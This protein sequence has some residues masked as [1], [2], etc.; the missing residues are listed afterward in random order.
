MLGLFGT[1]LALAVIL[2]PA[3]GGQTIG[4][5]SFNGSSAAMVY[6]HLAC[7]SHSQNGVNIGVHG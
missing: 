1:S 2:G 7:Y 5:A 6:K 3:V 4:K